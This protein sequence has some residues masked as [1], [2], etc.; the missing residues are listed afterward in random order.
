MRRSG[1][2]GSGRFEPVSW[3]QALDDITTQLSEVRDQFGAESFT[4]L[5]G[6]KPDQ[7]PLIAFARQF[8][9]PNVLDHNSLCDSSRRLG[10]QLT[11]G[12]GQERPLP[13]LYRPVQTSEGLRVAH[14]CRLLVLFG[15]NPAEARRFFW[16]W[17][18]IRQAKR[19]GMELVVV[20]PF[21][22]QTAELADCWLPIAPGT[23]VALILAMLRYVIEYD[24]PSQSMLDHEFIAQHVADWPELRAE[25]LGSSVDPGSGEI[26][27]TPAW[28]A[29]IT[30]LGEADVVALAQRF[31]TV[32]PSAA[33]IGMNGV[34]H[35]LGGFDA[36]RALA[37]LLA[38][39]GNIDR[40]GGLL[41]RAASPVPSLAQLLGY[42]LTSNALHKDHFGDFPLASHGVSAR[43]PRDIMKGI[44]LLRGPYAGRSYSTRALFVV[45]HNPLLTAPQSS[46]WR[47]ALTAR[48][49][50]HRD[51]YRLR[52]LVAH[53]TAIHDTALYADYVLPMA[54]FLERNGVV[55]HE[56][57]Q[58]CYSVRR[59]VVSPPPGVLSPLSL[60]QALARRLNDDARHDTLLA[61]HSDEW[62]EAVLASLSAEAHV[63]GGATSPLYYRK[64]ASRGFETASGRVEAFPPSLR[65]RNAFADAQAATLGSAPKSH[66]GERLFR[67]V[68][69]RSL[70]HSHS[71]TQHLS[72]APAARTPWI[73]M[74][75]DDAAGAGIVDGDQVRLTNQTG[76]H[77]DARIRIG[78]AQRNGVLRGFHGWGSLSPFLGHQ[79]PDAYNIN[80]LTRADALHPVSGNALYGMQWVSVELRPSP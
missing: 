6:E 74:S 60:A 77:I 53:D 33:S 59:A 14:D 2:R 37:L 18:G 8:G 38:V 11:L 45:H 5:F 41:L 21:R 31:G 9:T 68:V 64:Y 12:N 63:P 80:E 46:A 10:F 28:A 54:H 39:T 61:L 69:G 32:K 42:D 56:T 79:L 66:N 1:P 51:E 44:T 19:E 57:P 7:D 34:S 47:E 17:D 4:M 70:H 55:R 72:G 58:A 24:S 26:L 62:C 36:A 23:D 52:L 73:W 16:L 29:T 49:D 27:Y 30:G 65:G 3:E 15:E 75:I 67:L 22:S 35:Q 48:D 20:D 78:K 71:M 76:C 40:P 25:M 13:D 50:D 43:V